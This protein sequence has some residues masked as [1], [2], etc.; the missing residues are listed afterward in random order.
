MDAAADAGRPVPW[1][2]AV[3]ERI[4]QQTARVRSLFLRPQHW[5]PFTPGQHLDIRL[6]APDGYQAQRSYS[7]AS[8]PAEEG[9]YELVV[10]R[11]DDG[12]VSPYFHDVAEAGD[13][14]E[15]RGPFGGHFAWQASDGGPLLLVGGG[16]GVAPLLSIL[17]HRALAA[18]DVP[19]LLLYAARG[20]D[21][22]IARDELLRRD[23]AEA[24]FDLVLAL[25]RDRP[26][27]PQDA[28]RRVDAA[29]LGDALAR[30]GGPPR[31][32]F[33]CGAN[34]FVEAVTA[35]LLD[36]GL[37]PATIRTERFGG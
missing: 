30:L 34:P 36:L 3:I 33:V 21:D 22:L 11:L 18:P 15:I 32:T 23:E 31:L 9:V 10:E 19:A 7:V 13:A 26:R 2:E 25:S 16:S 37:D 14:I 1:Q 29:M 17:R 6:T 5:R 35:P 20:W 27:R 4:A 28:G 12:E 8:A 24:G